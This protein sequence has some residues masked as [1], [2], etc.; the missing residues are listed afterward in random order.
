[1]TH[2]NRSLACWQIPCLVF[3]FEEISQQAF[4]F[5]QTKTMTQE[6]YICYRSQDYKQD[7]LFSELLNGLI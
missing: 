7:A 4:Y 2:N 3:I 6:K 1:M 5:P